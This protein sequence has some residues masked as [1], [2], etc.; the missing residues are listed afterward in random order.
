[1]SDRIAV[2]NAGHVAQVDTPRGIYEAPADLFVARFMGHEN[3]VPIRRHDADGVET[4]LGRLQGDFG[5]G[6][7]LLLRPEALRLDS[8]AAQAP[9]R[10]AAQV[11]ERLYRGG[12]TE[13]RLQCGN[14]ELM[15]SCANRGQRIHEV[16]E[17]VEVGLSDRGTATLAD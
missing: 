1:M 13:Y 6:N 7:H 4:T 12:T 2:L 11:R 3:F 17:T 8:E 10:F 14:V 5:A 9:N 15:A 16:G